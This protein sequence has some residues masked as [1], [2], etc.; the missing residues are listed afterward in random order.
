MS[1]Y[2]ITA[3]IVS[4]MTFLLITPSFASEKDNEVIESELIEFGKTIEPKITAFKQVV[5]EINND[6]KPFNMTI[7]WDNVKDTGNPFKH[8]PIYTAFA[9]NDRM[10]IEYT[11]SNNT[12]IIDAELGQLSPETQSFLIANHKKQMEKET[13]K[14]DRK[15]M[16]A[17][18]AIAIIGAILIIA[19][20]TNII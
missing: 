13:R 5:V 19:I 14:E 20:W 9:P 4:L 15:I 7:S 16:F 18:I 11:T 2:K 12:V 10:T 3:I 6:N 17:A 8:T 1:K